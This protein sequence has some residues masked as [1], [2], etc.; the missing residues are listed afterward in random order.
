MS[1]LL[2]ECSVWFTLFLFLGQN[3]R[4]IKQIDDKTANFL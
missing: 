2:A 3:V 1:C 4:E